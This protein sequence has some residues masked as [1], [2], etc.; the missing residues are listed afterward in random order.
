MIHRILHIGFVVLLMALAS[1]DM[2]ASNWQVTWVGNDETRYYFDA[3][4]V[5][6]L[7]DSVA[8]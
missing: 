6:K 8:V 1:P 2:L 7:K 4:S 3:D 5:E